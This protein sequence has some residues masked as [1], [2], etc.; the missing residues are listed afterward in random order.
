MKND[1]LKAFLEECAQGNE[2]AYAALYQHLEKPVYR[3]IQSK[4]NDPV[5]SYDLFH[6]V[7]M[8]IWR[9]AGKFEGRSSVK[10]WVF[11]ITYRK[12]MTHFRSRR[13]LVLSAEIPD[14]EDDTP[15]AE[16]CLIS[17]QSAGHVRHCVDTLKEDHRT[18]IGLVFY[19][20][21]SYREISEALNVPEGTIKT[22]VFHAK[23]LLLRC[24]SLTLKEV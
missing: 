18:A 19:E 20:D 17:A 1:P 21:M 22:R 7:M 4:L 2:E 3:F 8:E 6:I 14:V 5:E 9:S 13:D 15:S 16:S 23:K 12:I 24:L 11:A 10:T